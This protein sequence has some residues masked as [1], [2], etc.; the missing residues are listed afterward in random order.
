MLSQSESYEEEYYRDRFGPHSAV[1]TKP[2]RV[3]ETAL[4][5]PAPAEPV[6]LAELKLYCKILSDKEDP[7]LTAMGKTARALIE[8]YTKR[9]WYKHDWTMSFDGAP[10]RLVDLVY[11]PIITFT[12]IK[13]FQLDNTEVVVDTALYTVDVD[14]DPPRVFLNSGQLWTPDLRANN[15]FKIRYL[16]GFAIPAD[17]VPEDIKL[18]IKEMTAYLY[19]HRGDDIVLRELPAGVQALCFNYRLPSL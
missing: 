19:Q 12:S 4:T 11:G 18:A 14:A 3:G 10:G 17:S 16:A 1:T 13:A 7:I 2:F 8:R 15:S 6:T 5:P 9:S